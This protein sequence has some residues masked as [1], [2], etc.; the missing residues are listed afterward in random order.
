MKKFKSFIALMMIACIVFTSAEY[1]SAEAKDKLTVITEENNVENFLI[2]KEANRDIVIKPK[3]PELAFMFKNI[4]AAQSSGIGTQVVIGPDS[5]NMI[6]DTYKYPYTAIARLTMTYEGVSGVAYGTGFL[7]GG[8]VLATAGHCLIDVDRNGVKHKLTSLK[9]EFG[10]SYSRGTAYLTLN[11]WDALIYYGDYQTPNPATD[12]GFVILK[13]NV[14]TT[15][16]QFGIQTSVSNNQS[17]FITGYPGDKDSQCRKM[18]IGEGNV[19][20]VNVDYIK[21][22]VDTYSGQSGS[23]VYSMG[24]D[25]PYAT[26]IHYGGNSYYNYNLAR[27][28]ESGLVQWLFDNNFL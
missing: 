22:N 24:T 2:N 6:T 26:A 13:Q 15:V 5:R 17:V 25:G 28:L 4:F 3:E 16:G 21:H 9:V 10:Y 12:Y 14:A 18:Y 8:N 20:E 11:G 1:A 23:P 7:V 19:T 27:R